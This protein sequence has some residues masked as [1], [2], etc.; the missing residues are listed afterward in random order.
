MT[1]FINLL[2]GAWEG[3]RDFVI[4]S[5]TVNREMLIIRTLPY[6]ECSKWRHHPINRFLNFWK[7]FCPRGFV[8]MSAVWSVVGTY[9]IVTN[10][11]R[12]CSLKWWYTLLICLVRGLILGVLAISSAPMLSSNNW[13]WIFGVD[14]SDLKLWSFNSFNKFMIGIVSR[15]AC[16]KQQYSASV[17]DR[18]IWLINFECQTIGH[19]CNVTTYPALL[20]AVLASSAAVSEICVRIYFERLR[21]IWFDDDA[22]GAGA[23]EVFRQM[24]HCVSVA[25]LRARAES[26]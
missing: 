16:D 14:P 13:Q 23:L 19:P 3:C 21:E 10:F 6:F 1:W 25:L 15:S 9:V 11:M 8:S 22:S 2:I 24:N 26:S 7:R 20:F 18:Q 12:T 17:V 4:S 5:T